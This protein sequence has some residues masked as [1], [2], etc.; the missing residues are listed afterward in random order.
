MIHIRY[1]ATEALHDLEITGHAA[2]NTGN[3]IVCAG[4][5]AITYTLAG[6][7]MNCDRKLRPF[8]NMDSGESMMSCRRADKS[9][10][11]FEMAMIGYAQIANEYP[12]N[13]KIHINAATG[14]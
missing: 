12:N 11:A 2:Y 5:S 9:D 14:C 6:W 4:V 8:F 13:V 3:D 7:L 1:T 10:T